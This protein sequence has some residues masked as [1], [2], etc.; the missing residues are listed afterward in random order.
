MESKYFIPFCGQTSNGGGYR[1]N[2]SPVLARFLNTP[3]MAIPVAKKGL[4]KQL[5][6]AKNII[7]S[8]RAK[9]LFH[10]GGYEAV[11]VYRE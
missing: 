3:G 1:L 4:F 7:H 11:Q 2:T 9:P 6:T 8:E 10:F 5:G